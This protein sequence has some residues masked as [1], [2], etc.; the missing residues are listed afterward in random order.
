MY[1]C[2]LNLQVI[3]ECEKPSSLCK[4]VYVSSVCVCVCVGSL[5]GMRW[6][7]CHLILAWHSLVVTPAARKVPL[8]AS[9]NSSPVCLSRKWPRLCSRAFSCP[10]VAVVCVNESRQYPF[11]FKV[12]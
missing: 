10:F 3:N 8:G 5:V 9:L 1:L 6:H 12:L 2:N 7:W 11:V 4:Y